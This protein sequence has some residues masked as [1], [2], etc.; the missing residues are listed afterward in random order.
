MLFDHYYYKDFLLSKLNNKIA[1][2]ASE[3]RGGEG[4]PVLTWF[5]DKNHPISNSFILLST[6]PFISQGNNSNQ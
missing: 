3:Y 1:L 6:R 2:Q 4:L 5:G